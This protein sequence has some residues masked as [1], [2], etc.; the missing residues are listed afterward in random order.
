MTSRTKKDVLQMT[1]EEKQ[2]T[3]R[4]LRDVALVEKWLVLDGPMDDLWLG[5]M[6]T[7]L[8]SSKTLSL[9]EGGSVAV[10]GWFSPHLIRQ[11]VYK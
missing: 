7:V 1:S 5:G 4:G 6:S 11:L 10:P 3:L 8:D 9:G 2:R